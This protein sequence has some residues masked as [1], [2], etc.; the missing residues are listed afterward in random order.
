[1]TQVSGGRLLGRVKVKKL[2]DSA[3]LTEQGDR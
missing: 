2:Y 1:M 3:G